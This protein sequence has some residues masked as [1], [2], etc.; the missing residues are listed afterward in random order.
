[1]IP[2]VD[3]VSDGRVCYW[4]LPYVASMLLMWPRRPCRIAAAC[5]KAAAER[6]GGQHS[7]GTPFRLGVPFLLHYVTS[8]GRFVAVHDA[9][10]GGWKTEW[11]LVFFSVLVFAF[12][13]TQ[14]C[15]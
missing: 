8:K 6:S 15:S 7:S 4:I 3:E 5:A 2:L 10:L 12:L 11:S 14:T 1:M 13:R 9:A